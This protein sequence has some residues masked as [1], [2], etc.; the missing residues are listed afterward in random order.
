MAG[1]ANSWPFEF[2]GMEHEI[3]DPA[4]LYFLLGSNVYNPQLQLDLSQ[5]GPQ[6]LAGPRLGP[7]GGPAAAPGGSSGGGAGAGSYLPAPRR[8]RAY[9]SAEV[10]KSILACWAPTLILRNADWSGLDSYTA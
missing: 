5:V 10:S 2:A 6:G 4:N 9:I 8:T 7:S 1:A 3:T